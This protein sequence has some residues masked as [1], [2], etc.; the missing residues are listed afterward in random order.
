MQKQKDV[1]HEIDRLSILD[2]SELLQESKYILWR[3]ISTI[4]TQLGWRSRHIG[5][6]QWG[7]QGSQAN[8]RRM[9]TAPRRMRSHHG[10][11]LPTPETAAC[12][13]RSGDVAWRHR[14][15]LWN[16]GSSLLESAL[17]RGL[18]QLKEETTA[19]D[20]WIRLL[21]SFLWVVHIGM[22]AAWPSVCGYPLNPLPGI[23]M[24]S[25][26]LMRAIFSHML[27]NICV[28]LGRPCCGVNHGNLT[29]HCVFMLFLDM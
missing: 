1:L 29:E 18:S 14:D 16:A 19:V 13:E 5:Y 2:P 10:T 8:P 21:G 11:L 4:S 28:V 24:P 6:L 12:H 20:D 7:Q 27:S 22:K 15:R 26:S 9:S 23:L 3:W 25:V 17:R